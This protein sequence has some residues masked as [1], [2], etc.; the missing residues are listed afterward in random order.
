MRLTCCAEVKHF[1][2]FGC[3]EDKRISIRILD[4]KGFIKVQR[5]D[6]IAKVAKVSGI[7]SRC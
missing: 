7:S 2:V 5:K 3:Q 4:K 1:Y 6:A